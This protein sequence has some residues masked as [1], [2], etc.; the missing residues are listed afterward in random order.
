ML[1]VDGEHC[2]LK[3]MI[4]NYSEGVSRFIP[5]NHLSELLTFQQTPR[6]LHERGN[7]FF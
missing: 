1:E 6:L 7:R 5:A 2:V 4:V 3:L